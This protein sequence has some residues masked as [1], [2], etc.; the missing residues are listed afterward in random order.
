MI[1]ARVQGLGFADMKM[2]VISRIQVSGHAG[3][4]RHGHDLV[5]AAVSALTINFVN[6]VE[7]LCEHD[8]R[9]DM[10]SGWLDVQVPLDECMQQFARG[11]VCGLQGVAKEHSRHLTMVLEEEVK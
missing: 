2:A 1:V 8:L 10:K 9:P 3:A 4:G 6:S 7:L 11:L 5:C